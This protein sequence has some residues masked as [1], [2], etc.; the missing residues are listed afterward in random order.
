MDQARRTQIRKYIESAEAALKDNPAAAVNA[1][2]LALAMDPNNAEIAKAFAHASSVMSVAMADDYLKR[3]EYE[4]RNGH[5][6][7]A[8]KS[9]SRAA[10]GMPND[11]AVQHNAAHALLKAGG[12]LRQAGE[13]A[14]R[15]V[16]LA[17]RWVD[18][19]LLLVEVYLGA[20][21]P[22]AARRELE[23]ARE[24]APRDDRISELSKR[25]R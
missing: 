14:K 25:L 8:A 19:R 10:A 18:A 16:A 11:A 5:W 17:P 21:M 24:I 20:S 1:Y 23:A 4:A 7:E 12:D 9:Y 3:A 6:R 22:L 2:K 13:F 15:A